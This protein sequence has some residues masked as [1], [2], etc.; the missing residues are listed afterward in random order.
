MEN[1]ENNVLDE[2]SFLKNSE[3]E[4]Y[5]LTTAKWGKFL[6]IVGYVGL[7]LMILASVTLLGQDSGGTAIPGTT[8]GSG[9]IGI[10]YILFVIAYYF[11]VTFLY[12]FSVKIQSAIQQNDETNY[13]LAF[14][15]LKSL[16]KF[17]GILTIIIIS[18]Y[19]LVL[20]VA[21]VGFL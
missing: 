14:E 2:T 7:V 15:N 20:V 11:P 18:I 5:L 17:M 1:F 4:A 19:V 9:L 8:I 16:F 12:R 3:I 6:A 13:T 21:L 10:V